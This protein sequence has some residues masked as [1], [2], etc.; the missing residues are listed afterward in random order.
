LLGILDSN[1]ANIAKKNA[2]I[3][4]LLSSIVDVH[5]TQNQL[6]NMAGVEGNMRK[7]VGDELAGF[8]DTISEIQKKIDAGSAKVDD[9]D[10]AINEFITTLNG[11]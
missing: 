1:Y 9:F 5:E 8:A 7:T 6:L 2:A 11:N 10:N 3:T 4:A